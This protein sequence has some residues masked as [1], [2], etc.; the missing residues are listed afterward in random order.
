MQVGNIS[1]LVDIGYVGPVPKNPSIF[2]QWVPE[3]I[4]FE[5]W[6]P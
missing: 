5:P 6:K 3:C 1:G 2:E 4:D